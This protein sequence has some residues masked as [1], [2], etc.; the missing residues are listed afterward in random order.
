[1]TNVI[2]IHQT[3][4]PHQLAREINKLTDGI[5]RDEKLA[6][7]HLLTLKRTKPQG[8]SWEHYLKDCGV[9]ISARHADRLIEGF[10][11][12]TRKSPIKPKA[13]SDIVSEPDIEIVEELPQEVPRLTLKDA[14]E[15]IEYLGHVIESLKETNAELRGKL[16]ELRESEVGDLVA[17]NAALRRQLEALKPPDRCPW[18]KDDGGRK[19]AEYGRA[20]GDCV[21]RAITIATGKSY[22]EVFEALKE[23]HARYVKRLKPGSHAAKYE[24]GR[25]TEPVANGCDPKVSSAYLKSLGWQYTQLRERVCLQAGALPSGRLI[26]DVHRHYLALIDGVIHDTYDSGGQ[27]KRPVNGYWSRIASDFAEAAE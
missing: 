11:G 14:R 25:R 12:P 24:A 9:K 3:S 5:A 7:E 2:A 6:G 23:E 8:I 22:A 10:Q 16:K 1:M 18:V 17:E 21:A 4:K 27:G 15:E 19:A 13:A 26:V 20:A